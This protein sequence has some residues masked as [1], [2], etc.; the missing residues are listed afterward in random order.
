[1]RIAVITGASSGI[2]REYADLLAKE[3]NVDEIW[4]L[5]RDKGKLNML[6]DGS[7]FPIRTFSVD[8]SDLSSVKDFGSVLEKER[9]DVTWLVNSAGFGKFCGYNNISPEVS[10][11]MIKTNCEGVMSVTLTVLPFMGEGA[12]IINMGSAAAFQPLPYENIYAAT[13]AF[14]RSYSRALNRELASRAITVTCA[15]PSWVQTDFFKTANSFETTKGATDYSGIVGPAMVAKK[16]LDDA[17]KGRDMSVVTLRTKFEHLL[18]KI[19]PQSVVMD[20]WMKRQKL[21]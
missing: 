18:A 14:V 15:C 17:K 4:A 7:N 16:A 8:V 19:L 10:T 6:A 9:P 5:A 11:A 20:T 2:G 21:N 13:K 12:R 1:M 3:S